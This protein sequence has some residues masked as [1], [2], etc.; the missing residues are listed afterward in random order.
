PTQTE[1]QAAVDELRA[2]M[3]SKEFVDI[4]QIQEV[5]PPKA[6][7]AAAEHIIAAAARLE[8]SFSVSLGNTVVKV[9]LSTDGSPFD[10]YYV[11]EIT[12]NGILVVAN[13]LHPHWGEL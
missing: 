10:P 11:S 7:E 13:Q 4:I 1:V 5:P 2:E 6:I 9:Y 3:E 8:P 12:K